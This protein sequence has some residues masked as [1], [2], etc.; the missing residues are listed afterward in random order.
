MKTIIT[1]CLL[2]LSSLGIEGQNISFKTSESFYPDSE[3]LQ[4]E[5]ITWGYLTVPEKWGTLKSNKIKIAVA[6]LK[7][8]SGIA[9]ADAVAFVQGGPGGS[10]VQ[11]IWY[12]LN[13]PIRQ[14]K[15]IVLFDVRGTGF[16]EPRLCPDLG[17]TFLEI[18]AKN[19]TKQEDVQQKTAAAMSCKQELLNKNIDIGS[20]NSL[21]VAKDLNALRTE[22]GY[23]AWHV[24]GVSY[25][26]YTS[27]V[28]ASVFPGD[29]TSLLLD[30]PVAAISNYY[31]QNTGNYMSGLSKVFAKCKDDPECNEQYPDLEN[32]FYK[33]IAKLEQ[34]PITV[35]VDKNVIASEVFTYNAEDFKIATQ[36]VLY[37]KQ[38][39][40]VLPLLIYQFYE[41]NQDALGNLVVF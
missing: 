21:S 37:H 12:W 3:R 19:Q 24:Y 9:R 33:T 28:Y 14:Q 38:L 31:T 32:V 4:K 26:T 2:F 35:E 10:G 18:L 25:G 8:T 1:F 40:E 39:V 29:V 6:V 7:N 30:S 20:Y 23:D 41:R 36:Q 34:E 15:D 13:H 22:L 11:A 17:N 5:S 27:Q 16:S